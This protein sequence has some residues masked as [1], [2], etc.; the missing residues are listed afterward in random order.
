MFIN[1]MKSNVCK[2]WNCITI[3]WQIDFARAAHAKTQYYNNWNAWM[4]HK[5][6]A[7]VLL[8]LKLK[9]LASIWTFD[10]C[11]CISKHDIGRDAGVNVL[12]IILK[13]WKLLHH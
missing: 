7:K 12:L 5:K 6:N 13:S 1:V 8:E 9:H 2:A 10:F 11:I 3:I 4:F